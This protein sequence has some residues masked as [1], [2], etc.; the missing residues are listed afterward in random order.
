MGLKSLKKV[1]SPALGPKKVFLTIDGNVVE[2]NTLP[3]MPKLS[4]CTVLNSLV[5]LEFTQNDIKMSYYSYADRLEIMLNYDTDIDLDIMIENEEASMEHIHEI[6]TS[7]TDIYVPTVGYTQKTPRSIS[8]MKAHSNKT[9]MPMLVVG[10][11]SRLEGYE[12]DAL[13]Y[14]HFLDLSLLQETSNTDKREEAQRFN[15]TKDKEEAREKIPPRKY[16]KLDS[17]NEYIDYY[18]SLS[19]TY[20]IP[21]IRTRLTTTASIDYAIDIAR[22]RTQY[23]KICLRIEAEREN[24]KHLTSYLLPLADMLENTYIALEENSKELIDTHNE[25]KEIE[26]ISNDL[27]IIYLGKNIFSID[28]LTDNT[29]TA[30]DNH[31]LTT[32]KNLQPFHPELIYA[33]YCGFEKDTAVDPVGFPA[34]TARIFYNCIE[35]IDKYYLRRERASS[36]TWMDAMDSLQTYIA[37]AGLPA[38]Q[39][40]HCE[41]CD[42]ILTKTSRFTLGD[43]KENCIIHNGISIAMA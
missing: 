3:P 41:A 12:E 4:A 9:I 35:N 25:L 5:I 19:N 27:N 23:T 29:D 39:R 42:D 22:L 21:V 10:S 8:L 17:D 15:D 43:M 31:A 11:D 34:R 24:I 26:T 37:L 32:F 30:Y 13:E 14:P 40:G 16:K 38:I 20:H 28:K 18:L 1:F 7:L 36:N 33:D 6:S 2:V